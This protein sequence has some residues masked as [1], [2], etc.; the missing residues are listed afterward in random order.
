MLEQG[1]RNTVNRM[2]K[3]SLASEKLFCLEEIRRKFSELPEDNIQE[4]EMIAEKA[5]L[6]IVHTINEKENILEKELENT[7][8]EFIYELAENFIEEKELP[9]INFSSLEHGIELDEGVKMYLNEISTIPLLT[10]TEERKLF[11]EILQNDTKKEEFLNT[12]SEEERN[13][14]EKLLVEDPLNVEEAKKKIVD[15]NLKLV[16]SIAKNY[17]NVGNTLSLMDLTQEGTLGL[18]RAI[19]KFKLNKGFKFSTYATFWIRQSVMRAL[20]DKARTIRIP[21]HMLEL[22]SKVKKELGIAFQE[23]KPEPSI[24]EISERLDININKVAEIML[25]IHQEPVSLEKPVDE[26]HEGDTLASFISD[27][28]TF[29]SPHTVTESNNLKDIL[30]SIL[31]GLDYREAMI[32]RYRYGLCEG[33]IPKT[34]DEIG[35]IFNITR[36]R[37]RQLELKA[38][39]KLRHPS[40]RRKI[41]DFR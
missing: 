22:I 23:G 5:G 39:R 40:R 4:I 30:N 1:I 33:D 9:E 38:L 36:E 26:E 29:S 25:H 14:I 31:D 41:E 8:E 13:Q 2:I 17:V 34:L 28:G 7:E 32:V 20:G 24:K 37:V 35:K 15:S 11:I 3:D 10:L 12:L 27:E 21:I 6:K 16:V 18:I 19:D